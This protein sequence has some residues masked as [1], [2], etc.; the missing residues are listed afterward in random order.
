MNIGIIGAGNIGGT[1][2]ELFAWTGHEVAVSNSRGPET[3]QGK[4][5]E[6]G[7]N[8]T[9]MTAKDAAKFGEVVLEAVPFGKYQDLPAE[10]LK[11]K[12]VISASN[13]YPNRDGDIDLS[14]T[15]QTGLVA[16]HL[17]GSRVVKAFNTIF[18]QHLRDQGDLSLP[19]EQRRAIFIAGDDADAKRVVTEL[20]ES[21]GFA[22]VDTGTLPESAVQ[23]PGSAIYAK[24]LT[25]DEAREMLGQN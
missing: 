16:Q 11:G 21:L 18:W 12:I 7:P 2:A 5:A 4:V 14:G 22:A 20:I 24:E 9:A 3:L 23:E 15:T 25:A 6:L 10:A 8:V 1:L 13:Y 19:L 17:S